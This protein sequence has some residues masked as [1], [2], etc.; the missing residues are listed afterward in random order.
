M[1]DECDRK[2]DILTQKYYIVFDYF[3]LILLKNQK[4]SLM[5]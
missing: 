2:S 5:K 3:I 4:H 1:N